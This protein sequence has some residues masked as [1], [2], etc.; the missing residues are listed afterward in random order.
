MSPDLS[1]V[2]EA[3]TTACADLKGLISPATIDTLAQHWLLVMQ[4]NERSNLTA[5]QNTA[6]AA[7]LHYRDS[8]E[9]LN[10]L[11][12][13]KLSLVD[14]GSG[15]GFPGMVLAAARPDWA[16]ALVEPRRKRASF[17]QA[18]AARLGLKNVRVILGSSEMV[19][20]QEYDV[21]VTRAT[22]S[23]DEDLQ[24]CM[25]WLRPEGRFLL[26]RG[27]EREFQNSTQIHPYT[28]QD[29]KRVIETWIRRP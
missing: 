1:S 19:P 23:R 4:W 27:P 13:P 10:C 17:L 29:A 25:R 3:I 14:F 28:L 7:W 24:V 6:E 20:D 16:C 26:Y 9:A 12:D 8:L 11:S 5:I 15:A 22:F 2:K 18:S 21:A